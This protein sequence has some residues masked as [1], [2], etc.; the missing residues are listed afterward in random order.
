[1]YG[2]R[3]GIA[4]AT[5]LTVLS[6]FCSA[7][8]AADQSEELI[9]AAK[10][11]DLEHVRKLLDEGDDVNAENDNGETALLYAALKGNLEMVKLLI[12][13]EADVEARDK[14]GFTVLMA[15]ASGGH[16]DV[17]GLL[18]EKGAEVNAKN[19][20]G[21]TALQQAH[22]MELWRWSSSSSTKEATSRTGTST[23]VR[24]SCVLPR[25]GA[26]M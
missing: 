8:F 1:M 9:A 5:L 6:V 19:V 20:D 26:W 4:M 2:L 14:D 7:G 25:E 12:E 3:I 22:G 23:T 15:A 13:R 24:F 21:E 11:G 16:L 17:A 10:K 18:I